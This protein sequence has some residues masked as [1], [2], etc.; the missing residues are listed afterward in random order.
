MSEFKENLKKVEHL[1]KIAQIREEYTDDLY[2]F[3]GIDKTATKEAIKASIGEKYQFYLSKQNFNGW[4][5][6][7]NVFI[8]SQP[9]I[10]YILFECKPEYDNY[11]L[12]LKVKELRKQF[13]SRTSTD[14]ELNTK[15][16]KEIV[17]QGLD[18]GLS[19]TQIG[20]IMD[21][22]IEE[23]GVKLV[24]AFPPSDSSSNDLSYNELLG[25]TYHE[26]FGLPNDA[27]C[28]ETTQIIKIIDRWMEKD[29]VKPAGVSA[30][31]DSVSD[32][33]PYNEFSGKTYYEIF[34]IS[35]DADYS[36]IKR[37]YDEK[38]E[39]YVN[40]QDEARWLL[41]SEAWE[42]LK[43]KDKREAYDKKINK[44]ETELEDSAPVLKVIGMKEGAYIYKNVKKGASFTETIVIKN[45]HKGRLQGRI[46]SDAEWLVPETDYLTYD[47]EQTLEIHIVTAKLPVNVYDAKGAITIEPDGGPPYLISFRII[48]EDL[49]IAADKFRKTYISL[50]A[51]CAGF[52]GSFSS[53][54]FSNSLVDAVFAG[55]IA[56][57]IAKFAV[58]ASLKNGLNIFKFPFGLIQGTACSIVILTILSHPSVNSVINRKVEQERAGTVTRAENPPVSAVAQPEQLQPLPETEKIPAI[59][60][61]TDHNQFGAFTKG[62]IALSGSL[63]SVDSK[64]A[65]IGDFW[66]FG[67][68]AMIDKAHYGFGCSNYDEL[69]FRIDGKDVDRAAGMA[70]IRARPSHVTLYFRSQN[71]DFVQK[72]SK[73]SRCAGSA[74][75]LA[76]DVGANTNAQST[77]Y[78]PPLAE[79]LK[80]S[81]VNVESGKK[82]TRA[83]SSIVKKKKWKPKKSSFAPPSRDDL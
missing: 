78:Q 17:K 13:I 56:Y 29:G 32:Y 54:P 57:A 80:S 52:I 53:S 61:R 75:P 31:S 28:S 73:G 24:E 5:I 35:K 36:E 82:N 45:E 46:I 38:Q 20:K 64:I 58:K 72:C 8:S 11:L 50:A 40:A 16:K 39:K 55:I 22:W 79:V 44:Q 63:T 71:W 34:G 81:S 49:E 37:S 76:I 43:D 42:T 30:P 4:E 6:L 9:A 69:H 59:A 62:T 18:I 65:G 2:S 70:V 26:I 33:L 15:A 23:Y 12:V 41:I 27:D 68:E 66:R 10:E 48:L 14:H 74:C 21:R 1:L 60:D 67:F 77:L 51:A 47:N 3:L 7:T 83:A 19:E 25:K